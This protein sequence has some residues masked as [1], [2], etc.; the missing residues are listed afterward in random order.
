MRDSIDA[1]GFRGGFCGGVCGGFWI[2]AAFSQQTIHTTTGEECEPR[3]EIIAPI[4]ATKI[5]VRR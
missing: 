5:A 2:L 4:A 3:C 1:A